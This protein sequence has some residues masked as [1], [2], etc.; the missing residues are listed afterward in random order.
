M[1]SIGE[2]HSVLAQAVKACGVEAFFYLI[3]GPITPAMEAC[4]ALNIRGVD[5]RDERAAAFAAIGYSRACQ[6]PGIVM[7]SA[8][9]GTMNTV[10]GISHAYAD[11]VPL[12][13]I[14]GS[15]PMNQFGPGA[16]Q[17]SDQVSVMLP[18]TKWAHKVQSIDR[19][20]EAVFTGFQTCLSGCPGP[21]YLD[22]PGDILWGNASGP[23]GDFIDRR[24]PPD[25]PR[26]LADPRLI[27]GA[28]KLLDQSQRPIIIAGGGV[29]WSKAWMELKDFVEA[30]GIPV[31]TTP[32]ARG[33][34][35]ETHPLC[36]NGARA[37]AFRETDCIIVVGTRANYVINWLQPPVINPESHI[38]QIDINP[39]ELSRTRMADV[40][41]SADAQMALRQLT[42]E[43]G[44]RSS[45]ERFAD[46]VL[47]L[48]S[49]HSASLARVRKVAD[50]DGV[51]IHPLRLC[52]ELD[53][54]LPQ[55]TIVVVDGQDI[56]GASRRALTVHRPGSMITPGVYGTMG[57]GMPFAIGAKVA[58]PDAPVLL[59]TGDGA[60]GFHAMELDTAVRHGL[61]IVVVI[62]NNGGWTGRRGAPGR[63][64]GFTDYHRLGD[65]FGV[66]GT[67]V[68]RPDEIGSAIARAFAFVE[69]SRKPAV[70][71]VITS[72]WQQ[73]GRPFTLSGFATA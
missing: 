63:E 27:A 23:V 20:R 48:Q 14:G 11:C 18:V 71:N 66:W 5:T 7:S 8:G 21:V 69:E 40:G 1:A 30:S 19:I 42:V 44:Q 67:C 64:L 28:A 25:P 65:V 56:L 24:L 43:A 52:A 73:S 17:E 41:I 10:T 50:F 29:L 38:I 15:T 37:T 53:S 72:T 9:P 26:P 36:L 2:G 47:H 39:Q 55:E 70:I 13:A 16:F 49:V 45:S 32:A 4:V 68:T 35:P 62:S 34:L 57:V 60:F 59:L 58:R 54:V 6:R 31:L 51:P 46:W 33:L 61:G 12:I 3:G 22:L